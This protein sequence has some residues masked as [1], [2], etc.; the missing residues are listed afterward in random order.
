MQSRRTR[1]EKLC[2]N[3]KTE[4]RMH[5]RKCRKNEGERIYN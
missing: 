2:A 1:G 5:D 3:Y 4:K